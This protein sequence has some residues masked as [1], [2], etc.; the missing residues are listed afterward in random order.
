MLK[1]K[2][3]REPERERIGTLSMLAQHPGSVHAGNPRAQ[4]PH[5]TLPPAANRCRANKKIPGFPEILSLCPKWHSQGESNSSS[6]DENHV[7]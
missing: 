4:P 2:R 3:D 6:M 1:P 7:S 5:T